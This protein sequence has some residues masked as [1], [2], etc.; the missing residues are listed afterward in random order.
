MEKLASDLSASERTTLIR[1][2]KKIGYK[3]DAE[4]KQE[5]TNRTA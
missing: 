3:A 5:T 1:L 4:V 2:L